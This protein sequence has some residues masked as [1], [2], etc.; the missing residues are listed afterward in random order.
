[1]RRNTIMICKN[2]TQ[3]E[4]IRIEYNERNTQHNN[5]VS[6][7]FKSRWINIFDEATHRWYIGYMMRQDATTETCDVFYVGWNKEFLERNV[8]L[9]SR[10]IAALDTVPLSVN[11]KGF[12]QGY[13]ESTTQDFNG[14]V[15]VEEYEKKLDLEQK[16]KNEKAEKIAF[17]HREF[18]QSVTD[19]DV[20]KVRKLLRMEPLKKTQKDVDKE[21]TKE[22]TKEPETP[23]KT[24]KT[25]AK[26]GTRRGKR[27]GKKKGKKG[28][29]ACS[30]DYDAMV[31][32][33]SKNKR[34][35]KK[36]GKNITA[37]TSFIMS[38]PKMPPVPELKPK[39]K[40]IDAAQ[41]KRE[42]NKER[43]FWLNYNIAIDVHMTD[44][45]G[46]NPLFL[47]CYMGHIEMT[48]LL[49]SYGF[50]A[51]IEDINGET[52]L[53][54]IVY[55]K[56]Q[57]YHDTESMDVYNM[58][59]HA[60]QSGEKVS[61]TKASGKKKKK[62]SNGNTEEHKYYVYI[63]GLGDGMLLENEM[64]D[65]CEL[66]DI[67]PNQLILNR[68]H[69]IIGVSDADIMKKIYFMDESFFRCSIL[70]VRLYDGNAYSTSS[71]IDYPTNTL[72][73][74]NFD[75]VEDI[76][77]KLMKIFTKYGKLRRNN[78]VVKQNKTRQNFSFVE[79]CFINNAIYAYNDIM[80]N[81][82]QARFKLN[83]NEKSNRRISVR[84]AK[85]IGGFGGRMG[86]GG[87]P[88][89]VNYN[90]AQKQQ[91]QRT[92]PKMMKLQATIPPHLVSSSAES[93]ES[94]LCFI[95]P[96][97]L[98][99]QIQDIRRHYDPAYVRWMPHMNIFFPFVDHR[100]FGAIAAFIQKEIIE[101]LKFKPFDVC[102]ER[103]DVFDHIRNRIGVQSK[104]DM[105][106]ETMFLK[107]NKD[108]MDKMCHL[109]EYLKQ[110]WPNYAR[111]HIGG[112][113]PHCTVGKFTI[114]DMSYYK[115]QFQ[116]RWSKREWKCDA[117]YLI[118]REGNK[119]FTV[120]N[121]ISFC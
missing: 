111:Q 72:Y 93:V 80:V 112:Y 16:M 12:K 98:W 14:T 106:I 87:R 94:A 96:Q 81:K 24:T 10:R 25:K 119:P 73:V 109:F 28:H 90:N 6:L 43:L 42:A 68:G 31:S 49:L 78:V 76:E 110:F 2:P 17:Y 91:Q 46:R 104:G 27:S 113:T 47:S 97:H 108:A 3:F 89:K 116:S 102:F 88:R 59:S 107:P 40:K 32:S 45:F 50:S 70:N 1:M 95:P 18:F 75:S 52:A 26:T 114:E 13:I 63:G 39:K 23:V 67:Y 44:A 71:K 54:Q 5:G 65:L 103:F 118:A 34:R 92:R 20:D 11:D 35:R 79:Y 85:D 84:F 60:M 58:V 101:T 33:K 82:H 9:N 121:K 29:K 115:M 7:P 100:Y 51:N 48:K 57:K 62:K 15:Y 120:R 19:N 86:S 21:D 37:Q 36:K 69:C 77:S 22:E 66:Y 8:A 53:D 74:S 30:T 61:S 55:G 38:G 83:K 117:V 64:I 4:G 41:V 56:K 99:T 105:Q